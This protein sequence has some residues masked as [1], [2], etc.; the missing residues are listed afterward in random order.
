MPSRRG[1]RS[2]PRGV[3]RCREAKR[4][5]PGAYYYHPSYSSTYYNRDCLSFAPPNSRSH[6]KAPPWLPPRPWL[7]C[8]HG[9]F[10][11]MIQRAKRGDS[12]EY[13]H[14]THNIKDH[15]TA[16][17]PLGDARDEWNNPGR[18]AVGTDA[19]YDTL[20]RGFDGLKRLTPMVPPNMAGWRRARAWAADPLH[21]SGAMT[22]PQTTW[23]YAAFMMR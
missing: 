13:S 4:R 14:H 15:A 5:G 1:W 18:V 11:F 20:G 9:S 19:C 2:T 21:T 22:V 6:A 8:A 16:R 17:V 23:Y 10:P 7:C 3:F 12:Q